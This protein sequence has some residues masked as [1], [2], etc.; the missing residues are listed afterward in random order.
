M[1]LCFIGWAIGRSVE[2]KLRKLVVRG[3]RDRVRVIS[4]IFCRVCKKRYFYVE[5]RSEARVE[6]LERE[7]IIDGAGF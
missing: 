7:G 5:R 2:V 4:R 1:K 6:W 3:K